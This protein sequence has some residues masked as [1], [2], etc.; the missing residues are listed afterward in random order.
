MSNFMGIFSWDA[1]DDMGEIEMYFSC[2]LERDLGEYKEGDEFD[3]IHFDKDNL[4]LYF[5][6]NEADS[7]PSMVKHFVLAD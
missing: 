4:A 7:E 5:Y 1:W 2:V 3:H 6:R